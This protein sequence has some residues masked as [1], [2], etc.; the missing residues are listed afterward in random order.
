MHLLE[1]LLFHM[2]LFI[3]LYVY[4]NLTQKDNYNYLKEV[5]M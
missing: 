4:E 1:M 3:H 5:G 2:A